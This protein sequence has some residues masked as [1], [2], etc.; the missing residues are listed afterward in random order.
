MHT[1]LFKKIHMSKEKG[2]RGRKD[3]QKKRGELAEEGTPEEGCVFL[4]SVDI[5]IERAAKERGVEPEEV[6]LPVRR[7]AARY[8]DLDD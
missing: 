7:Y 3:K 2:E 1:S 6:V 5:A 8:D 4:D